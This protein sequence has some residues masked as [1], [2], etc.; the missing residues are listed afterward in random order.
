MK[1]TVLY[2]VSLF[3]AQ[4]IAAQTISSKRWSDHFSYNNV[5]AI[6]EGD[7]KIIGAA[8]NGIFYYTPGNGE[9]IKL[10]KANGLHDIGI[11]AFDYNPQTKTGLVGYS[12][13]TMDIISPDGITYVVDIPLAAG[14][15]GSKKINHISIT[16][17]QAVVSVGY[18]VSIF[19]LKRKEFGKSAFFMDGGVYLSSNEAIIKDNIIYAATKSGVKTHE[20]NV[21]FPVYNT[22][23]TL[24][25]GGFTQIASKAI[26]AYSD[27]NIVYFQNGT[28][29]SQLPQTFGNISDVVVTN[30]NIIVT[31][32]V[33][34]YVY[35]TTGTLVN[36]TTVGEYCNTATRLGSTVYG[37]TKFSGIKTPELNAYK[38]DG[39]YYNYAYKIS[40]YPNNRYLI[41][42][43]ARENRFNTDVTL[44]E[45]PGF[46]YFTGSEW[47]YPSYFKDNADHFNVLDVVA[48]PVDNNDVF[49]TNYSFTPSTGLYKMKYDPTNKDFEFK[50]KYTFPGFSYLNRPVGFTYDDNDNLFATIG[51]HDSPTYSVTNAIA[52]YDRLSDDFVIKA[53]GVGFTAQKPV[54]YE[55]MLWVPSPR[56]ND[57]LVYDLK[58]TPTIL[59][60]DSVYKI[61]ESNGLPSNSTGSLSVAI[62]QNDDAWIGTDNG[63]R[64]LPNAT[65]A[66]KGTPTVEPIVIEQAGLGEELFRDS[67]ILQ[68]EVDAGNRKWVSVDGGG[69]YYLSPDGQT[70]I[71]HFT[72]ENSPLPTNSVTDIKVDRQT[73]RVYFVT[74]NGVVSYQGDVA[75]V[76]SDFGNIEVYPNP[77]VYSNFKGDVTIR[78]L[79]MKTNIRIVDAAGNL[80]HQG[81]A[82][83]GFYKW[84]LANQRGQRVSSGVYFVL[85]TNEKGTDKATAKIA[86]VN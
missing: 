50:K 59:S 8:E 85:M 79:A 56:T 77:V 54:F 29:F 55:N 71:Q 26:I 10:S 67:Q 75:D 47:V 36:T 20:L 23:N 7:G 53:T 30:D 80:V 73:G 39:P 34:I 62:D 78:G 83:G 28:G 58:S 19:D 44:P 40:L 84:N 27:A 6:R 21:T 74:Y 3:C 4:N 76:S 86:V 22:W 2:I 9:I 1:K 48:D 68:I 38:P 24:A 63:L 70:T 32:N 41:S 81:V 14:Y 51:F 61:S 15:N 37:G 11:T 33:R 57:F 66:I 69:V 65:S 82:R 52:F 18:G 60:D 13:G 46:Y 31:D 72:K 5:F 43:G 49:F 16:G 35:N 25:G 12:N 17:E 45:N 64:I 42:T